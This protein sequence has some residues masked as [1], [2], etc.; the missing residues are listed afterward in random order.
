M[1]CSTLVV[2]MLMMV[3]VQYISC[4]LLDQSRAGE[5]RGLKHGWGLKHGRKLNYRVDE[6]CSISMVANVVAEESETQ[7]LNPVVSVKVEC[8]SGNYTNDLKVSEMKETKVARG[9]TLFT[10]NRAQGAAYV[11]VDGGIRF[12]IRKSTFSNL[13]PFPGVDTLAP[14]VLN[15]SMGRVTDC[16]F[17]KN[18]GFKAAGALYTTSSYILR[19]SVHV[20]DT[21]MSENQAVDTGAILVDMYAGATGNNITLYRN[22]GEMSGSIRAHEYASA[23]CKNCAFEGVGATEE[24][25]RYY[26]SK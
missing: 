23:D 17:E 21:K 24:L 10:R 8:T 16:I 20:Y 6:T 1:L 18:Q 7:N 11:L 2:L 14:L 15:G 12:W 4:D 25:L 3:W 9:I 22:D 5:R 13:P 26:C 19:T